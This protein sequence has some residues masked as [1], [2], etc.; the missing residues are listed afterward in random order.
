[1]RLEALM[2]AVTESDSAPI[3]SWFNQIDVGKN[4]AKV[5]NVVF[6]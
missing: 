6:L 3:H 4:N 1:M 5:R 2:H